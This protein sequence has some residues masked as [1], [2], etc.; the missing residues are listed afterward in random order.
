MS[1]L[2]NTLLE[3]WGTQ[4]P[5]R[6]PGNVARLATSAS[7]LSS[8]DPNGNDAAR[9]GVLGGNMWR[10]TL[11]LGRFVELVAVL[12][13]ITAAT[14]ACLP[15]PEQGLPNELALDTYGT[16]G[17]GVGAA[18]YGPAIWK[19]TS[20]Y[21]NASRKPGQVKIVVVHTTQGS[22]AGA[23]SWMQNPKAKVSAHYC[24]SKKGEVVQLVKEED[25]AW[26]VGSEN[27]YTIGIEHE[28]FVSDANWVTP[29]LLDASAKLS[30]YLVKKWKLAPTK[31]NIKGHVELPNQTHTDPGKYWPWDKYVGMVA[32]CVNGTPP[33]T[34]CPG[35]CDD[36]N[37]C[38]TDACSGNKCVHTNN[39]A[40]C[41]DGTG[42]TSGDKCSGGKCLAG[43]KKICDDKNVCTT[44]GCDAKSG[45][46]AF[47]NSTSLCN[48]GNACTT[49]DKCGGGKCSGA[50]KVCND[51][52]PCTDDSC[53]A[54]TGACKSVAN[55]KPCGD[56]SACAGA[57]VC[58][59][60]SCVP[61]K[62]KTCN[63][64]NPCTDDGCNAKTG[65]CTYVPNAAPCDDGS[66]CST[67]DTCAAGAC[68]AGALVQCNDN[69]PCTTD[70]CK[71]GACLHVPSQ[72][73]CDDGDPCTGGD[74]CAT[75]ACKGTPKLCNDANPCTSDACVSG[76]CVFGPLADAC[77]DGNACTDN[78]SCVNLACVGNPLQC[79]D[80]K[81][82]TTDA[83][84]DGACTH[85][86]G[87]AVGTTCKGNDLY[88]TDECGAVAKKV[89]TCGVGNVCKAGACQPAANPDAGPSNEP[90]AAAR[91]DDAVAQ[92]DLSSP[93]RSTD[94]QPGRG[95]DTQSAGNDGAAPAGQDA[96]SVSGSDTGGSA[97]KDGSIARAKDTGAVQR[98]SGASGEA[99]PDTASPFYT[100]PAAD[101]SCTAGP[102]SRVGS[103][104]WLALALGVLLARRR[105]A[106]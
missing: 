77:D 14:A 24:I 22:F 82:C 70:A 10:N 66:A 7:L 54:T 26:H 45:N 91:E 59:G 8:C 102:S 57:S 64:N 56:G 80:G 48:D 94:T 97:G 61:G 30:C 49:G 19:P 1:S 85:T 100:P 65:V 34:G 46:C 75:G 4:T 95:A 89:K 43:T 35:G 92:P 88:Q 12:M 87:A 15:E 98:G 58:S 41:S 6:H 78:D 25:I 50:A 52:N 17:A 63:D 23:V 33:P 99:N 84:K 101:S 29:Q 47:A 3:A 11:N 20:N 103:G 68:K 74:S 76:A 73:G 31:S 55:S 44:D 53:A 104:W 21:V 60:G 16:L 36:K 40:S 71:A 2:E 39:T 79:D 106:A 5:P 42:C 105:R 32:A 96:G 18:E 27:G 81:P 90:D 28:G 86:G 62:P 38:T 83:C 51:N 93:G 13:A 67:G 69:N 37:P 9:A 72:A